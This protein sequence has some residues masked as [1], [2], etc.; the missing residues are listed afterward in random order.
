MVNSSSVSRLV[1]E[2]SAYRINIFPALLILAGRRTVAAERPFGDGLGGRMSQ[3]T[4]NVSKFL[5]TKAGLFPTSLGW[6][7]LR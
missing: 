7:E 2:A 6:F 4:R 1:N 3:Q 5:S